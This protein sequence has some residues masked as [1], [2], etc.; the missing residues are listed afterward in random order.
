MRLSRR[1]GIKIQPNDLLRNR[2]AVRLHF[3][4]AQSWFPA[5]LVKVSSRLRQTEAS[6]A[7]DGCRCTP[8]R[9]LETGFKFEFPDL[10]SALQEIYR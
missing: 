5:W 9:F 1:H 8:K 4:L 7:L 2:I 6:L 3:L 10:H